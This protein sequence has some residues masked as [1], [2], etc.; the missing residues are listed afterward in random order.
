MVSDWQAATATLR[1]AAQLVEGVQ[2]GLAARGFTD[3]R[4]VHGFAFAALA[5]GDTTTAGLANALGI[6]KQAAAQLVDHLVDHGYV[7][8]Q[9]DPRDR[10]AQR[11]LLTD[12][13]HACTGA[14]Q[15]AAAEVVD[16]WRTQ[17]PAAAFA[18]FLQT[19][20]T[21]EEPGRL[22]PAW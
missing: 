3:V 6:T 4:P 22:R 20:V 10:R 12:R 17:V 7:I 19:L 1:V 9:S 21:I 8:R 16:F 5:G 2:S 14:A 11:L 13:G 18:D 15:Q